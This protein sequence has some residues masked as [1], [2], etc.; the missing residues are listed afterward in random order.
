[1]K[2]IFYI[3]F[4]FCVSLFAASE[5]EEW[6]NMQ[7][8]SY[9]SYK[10]D[11]DAQ[12]AKALQDDWQ[13]FKAF[14]QNPLEK[15]KPQEFKPFAKPLPKAPRQ[16][17]AKIKSV[18]KDKKPK[19]FKAPKEAKNKFSVDFFGTSL[20][21]SE[22]K[23]LDLRLA[24]ISNMEISRFWSAFSKVDYNTSL[25]EIKAHQKTH[26]LNDWGVLSL[27]KIMSQKYFKDENIIN[28]YSWFLLNKLGYDV[29]VGYDK[30]IVLL[31]NVNG[32]L[33]QTS[34]FN[35]DNKRYFA[36]DNDNKALKIYKEQ[37][38]KNPKLFSFVF[39]QETLINQD[40]QN[41]KISFNHNKKNYEINVQFNENFINF[42]KN[43]PQN[44]YEI[45]FDSTVSSPARASLLNALKKELKNKDQKQAVDFLLAFVQKGFAYKIDQEQFGKEKVLFV[46][47]TLYYPFS[48]CEDRSILFAY[49]VRNLLGL[50]VVGVKYSDHLA[51]AVRFDKNFGDMVK[52]NNKTYTICDPTYVNAPAGAQMPQYKGAKKSIIKLKN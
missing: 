41:K 43:F 44:N 11:Q 14:S 48:D 37:N 38:T 1:M 46:E 31:L 36:L 42:Y 47:E 40:L 4:I 6:L 25:N 5:Y 49:L 51:T 16:K 10:Q 21:F 18:P 8:K 20:E 13:E 28:L 2:P 52:I 19:E 3:I 7:N 32:F 23:G 12:F 29:R 24:Q 35:V 30:S 27:V 45:Y 39:A 15:P 34:F 22:T 33:Y 50:E 17:P 26:K 9:S